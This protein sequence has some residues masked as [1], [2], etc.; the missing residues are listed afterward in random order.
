M[1]T[2]GFSLIIFLGTVISWIN[3]LA[4]LF[5]IDPYQA[6]LPGLI[7]LYLSAILAFIGTLYLIGY[8]LRKRFVRYQPSFQRL[9]VAWR[10]AIWF[11]TLLVGLVYLYHNNL[12]TF[13]NLI[14]LVVILTVL[15]F[16]FISYKKEI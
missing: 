8:L 4:V 13:L 16:F 9:R 14:L 3:F 12:L 6:G 5:Y 15:E 11:T 2:R 7:F 1:T 10:Q